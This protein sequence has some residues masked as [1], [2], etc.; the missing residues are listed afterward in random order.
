MRKEAKR[1]SMQKSKTPKDK[2]KTRTRGLNKSTLTPVESKLKRR[3]HLILPL[4]FLF[5]LLGI[6]TKRI[7]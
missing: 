5:R 3:Y 7:I 1:V 4:L 2:A 6:I